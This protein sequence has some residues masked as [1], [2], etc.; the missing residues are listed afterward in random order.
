[1]ESIYPY[2]SRKNE[3]ARDGLKKKGQIIHI[4]WIRGGGSSNVDKRCSAAK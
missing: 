1:M 2:I 4:L 3:C